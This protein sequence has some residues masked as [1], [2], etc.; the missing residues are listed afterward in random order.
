MGY[1]ELGERNRKRYPEVPERVEFEHH[2]YGLRAIKALRKATGFDY[3]YLIAL[4]RGVPRMD[5]ATGEP[6]YQRDEQGEPLVDADG[7]PV[8]V[9]DLDEDALVGIVWLILWNAGYKYDWDGFDLTPSGL[10]VRFGD[11]SS[12][13]SGEAGK[14]ETGTTTESDPET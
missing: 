12:A 2:Q 5:K 6:V 14:A 11:D 7:Q 9:T 1:V 13:E 3:E 8:F 10:V 4:L